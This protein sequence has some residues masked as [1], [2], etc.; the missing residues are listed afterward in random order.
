MRRKFV[1]VTAKPPFLALRDII[2]PFVL[3]GKT[4]QF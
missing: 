4:D 3:K 2:C 1:S